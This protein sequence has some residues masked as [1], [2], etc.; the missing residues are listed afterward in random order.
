MTHPIQIAPP[1]LKS[2]HKLSALELNSLK[3]TEAHTILT[4]ELLEKMR[5]NKSDPE[6][7]A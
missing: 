5:D 7:G 3:F 1:K 4:P 2:A 6:S